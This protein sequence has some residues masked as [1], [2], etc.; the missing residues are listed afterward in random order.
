MFTSLKKEIKKVYLKNQG[1]VKTDRSDKAKITKEG[2][3]H[4]GDIG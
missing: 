3:R 2:A 1:T 4:Y